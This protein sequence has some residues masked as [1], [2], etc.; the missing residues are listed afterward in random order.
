MS[1]LTL[2]DLFRTL[3]KRRGEFLIYDD[4]YRVRRH[5]YSDVTRAARGFAAKLIA[6]G[7][8]K[9]DKVLLWGENRP[10][11]IAC[12]WGIQLAG[13]I[14]VPI[15]YRSSREFTQRISRIVEA[16]IIV[17]GD[18][19]EGADQYTRA[20][21][22]TESSDA[23]RFWKFSDLDWTADGSI[24]S[25]AI[26]RDDIAQ[27]VFTSGATA[28]PK[29]VVIR[30][31]NI[32]A[33]TVPVAKEIDKYKKYARPFSPIR[34]LNLLPLSHMF[35]QSMA[36]NIPPLID[37]TVVFMRSFNPHDIVRRVREWRIS[38]IVC[39]PKILEVLK[40]HA[41]RI[42]P[43]AVEPAK[44]LSI[45]ARWWRYRKI[46]RMFGLKFWAFI[47]GAAPLGSALEDYWKRLGF[48]VIQGYGLTE[49]APIVTMNHPFKTNTGSVG[50]P[51]AGVEVKIA[52]DGEILVRGENVTTGYYGQ[53]ESASARSASYGETPGRTID[54]A[55]WLHTGDVGEQDAEGRLFI[56]GRKKE[57]IV[58]PEG[59]NVYPD[60]VERP[61]NAQAGVIESAV[62][63]TRATESTGSSERVH[64]VLVLDSGIDAETVI[65]NANSELADHQ[66]IRTFSVWSEGPLPRTEGTKKLK[67]AAIKAWVDSGATP[68]ATGG[69]DQLQSLIARFAGS[70]QLDGATSIEGLGLS[71]LER[72]ELMVALED[73]FQTRIDETKFAGAKTLDDL[74][75][76]IATAPQD[77]E[78]AEPVD[79]PSWN[80]R[81]LVRIVRSI[82]QATWILPLGRIFAWVRV[83]GLEHLEGLHGPVVFASNHQSHF[84]VPVILMALPRSWRRRIA[85]AALKEFFKAHFF[86]DEFSSTQ[87][88]TNRLNYYLSAFFFNIFPLPQR[89]AGARQTL[90]YIG[91]VAGDGYS[92]L[93]FPEGVRSASGD[94]KAFKPGIGMIGSRLD[95]PVVPV[96][97]DGADRVLH[98]SW[99]WPKPGPV[100]VTFGR[101][102]RLSGDNYADLARQVEQ[103]VRDLPIAGAT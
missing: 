69:G 34:F 35:G 36:T 44:G 37:G 95:L 100:S 81:G 102:M 21:D 56:R 5:S 71:S 6:H 3:E 46:H 15:D 4:G 8:L 74:R 28:E 22:G 84:D 70:R 2:V 50:K 62:I 90:R 24:P 31:R 59:L 85:P 63:G 42:D 101:P 79:F 97:I 75:A 76:V 89:E 67:R 25:I 57:M 26:D 96:R 7:V 54:E 72:V 10:E 64:A 68:A 9:G 98:T 99:K 77:A 83:G 20:T 86:P 51:I 14:A 27:I 18:D 32:L 53:D 103:A 55:G 16:K 78:V 40:E 17:V 93:L 1:V 87:V 58:T 13:A 19:T 48:V 23:I 91:E 61:L 65:R 12:Y 47:V 73:Q 33:N 41:L 29:G 30:H 38:V 43:D 88:L 66:R 82:S 39:V 80:R 49:T 52:E 60:D 94:M 45:P 92:V 11:W